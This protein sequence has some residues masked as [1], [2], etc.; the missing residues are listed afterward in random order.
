MLFEQL[1]GL[2]EKKNLKETSRQIKEGKEYLDT[3]LFKKNEQAIEVT[4]KIYGAAKKTVF[5]AF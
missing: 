3:F 5:P 1:P 2:V 4:K